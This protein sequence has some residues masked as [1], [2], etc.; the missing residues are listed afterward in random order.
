MSKIEDQLRKVLYFKKGAE[1]F[2]ER[3]D[4]LAALVKAAAKCDE[5]KFEKRL[6][7][8]T[9]DWCYDGI[10]AWNKEKE[11]PEFDAYDARMPEEEEPG[12]VMEV[13]EEVI[14]EVETPEGPKPVKK[15]KKKYVGPDQSAGSDHYLNVTLDRFG[16]VNGTKTAKVVEMFETGTTMNEVEKAIGGRHYN[17]LKTLEKRGHR[18]SRGP[19]GSIKLTHKDDAGKD[20]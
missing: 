14:V 1:S 13:T 8:P 12:P 16:C 18:V 19:G 3:Q 11:I 17:I 6:S 4:Y 9:K 7:E 15:T 5:D 20:T 2:K 10:E